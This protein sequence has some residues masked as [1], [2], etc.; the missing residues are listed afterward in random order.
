M[1][2]IRPVWCI[3]VLLLV[4]LSIIAI[5]PVNKFSSPFFDHGFL[6]PL[7]SVL[8][9]VFLILALIVSITYLVTDNFAG[10][11]TRFRIR[12]VAPGKC[13]TLYDYSAG[14]CSLRL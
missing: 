1:G 3:A 8:S 2:R 11:V 7:A 6:L 4:L 5:L 14:N 13:L 10:S 9:V 12:V